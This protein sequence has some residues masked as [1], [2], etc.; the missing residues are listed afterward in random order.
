MLHPVPTV[1]LFGFPIARLDY[2]EVLDRIAFR[3]RGD[4][5]FFFVTLNPE[6]ILESKRNPHFHSVLNQADVLTPDGTGILWA[7]AYLERPF[8]RAMPARL[9]QIIG[10]LLLI[11]F[12]HRGSYGPL[13]RRVTGA[14]L[15]PCAMRRAAEEGWKV[16]FLGAAPGVAMKAA[17]YF[18]RLYPTLEI[19]GAYAGT[20]DPAE[21]HL[22]REKINASGAQLLFVAYG[23]PRQE[24][25]IAR[26]LPYLRS[27]KVAVGIGGSFDFYAGR[28]RR[29][30]RVFRL[31]GLEWLWRLMREPSRFNRI[32]NATLRFIRLAYRE[33]GKK[34]V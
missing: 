13:R 12:H 28:I 33:K 21:D 27:V 9:L 8:R 25:W 16:F 15:L 32:C 34:S 6:M 22:I 14:D 3:L 4:R 18:R 31:L 5:A 26:N 20:P 24:V 23:C 17:D 7:A 11:P 10:S 19:A 30:P 29:A 1:D 2:P